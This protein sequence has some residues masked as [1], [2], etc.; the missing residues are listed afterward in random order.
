[1]DAGYIAAVVASGPPAVEL[2]RE[3]VPRD[4]SAWAA[5]VKA[6]AVWI[7]GQR[8]RPIIFEQFFCCHKIKRDGGFTLL[9]RSP[10]NR[11]CFLPL[12]YASIF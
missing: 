9:L 1:M 8:H 4:C 5:S 11:Y 7:S 2:D 3:V 10:S 6:F 12:F